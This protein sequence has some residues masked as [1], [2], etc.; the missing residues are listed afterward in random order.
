MIHRL[1]V[2]PME[3][4]DHLVIKR[5]AVGRASQKNK[6]HA[7]RKAKAFSGLWRIRMG[8]LCDGTNDIKKWIGIDKGRNGIL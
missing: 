5:D 6:S 4:R 3:A 7:Q 8:M 2:I 1:L